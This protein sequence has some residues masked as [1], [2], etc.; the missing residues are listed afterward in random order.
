MLLSLTLV[1]VYFNPRFIENIDQIL[2][3]KHNL[4]K[5]IILITKP[6]EKLGNIP[7]VVLLFL[8]IVVLNFLI[9]RSYKSLI[10]GSLSFILL[11]GSVYLLKLK[12]ERGGP[13]SFDGKFWNSGLRGTLGVFP[14][15]HTALVS[16]LSLL[17][18]FFFK[19]A[20]KKIYLIVL[21]SAS[22]LIIYEVFSL[23][24]LSDH[25]FSDIFIGFSLSYALLAGVFRVF[26]LDKA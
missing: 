2:V 4:S 11:L 7:L 14:S 13:H 21:F 15:G 12:T 3:N 8:T 22:T 16:F 6:A 26:K 23:W 18:I 25:W 9:Y 5:K 19:N 10:A 17:L 20:S 24:Y 1:Q